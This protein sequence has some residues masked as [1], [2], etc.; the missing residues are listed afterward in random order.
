LKTI[1]ITITDPSVGRTST[2]TAELIDKDDAANALEDILQSTHIISTRDSVEIRSLRSI[3]DGLTA[4]FDID[5]EDDEEDEEAAEEEIKTP[6]DEDV[7]VW[8]TSK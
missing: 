4:D 8:P 1:S 7:T 6:F 3:L 5:E 2:V